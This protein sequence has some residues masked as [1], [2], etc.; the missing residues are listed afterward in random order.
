MGAEMRAALP[1]AVLLGAAATASCASS[2]PVQFFAL[3]VSDQPLQQ[4]PAAPPSSTPVRVAAVHIPA[5]LDRQQIVR[6]SAPGKVEISDRHRWDAPLDQMVSNVLTQDLLRRLP[7]GAVVLPQ[8]PATPDTRAIVL[9]IL[10]FEP[11]AGGTV[12]LTGAWSLLPAASDTPLLTRRV[13][14][15]EPAPADYAG[16]VAAMSR[17]LGKLADEIAQALR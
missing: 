8:E 5:A 9:D 10:R 14:L 13:A 17:L 4:R 2:P 7:R 16:E 12:T 1:L 6:E 11:D 3:T 15:S